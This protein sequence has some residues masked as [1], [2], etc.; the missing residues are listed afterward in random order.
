MKNHV[1][2]LA[3]I[4][5]L[6][7]GVTTAAEATVVRAGATVV[8]IAAVTRGT[9]V[10][11]DSINKIYLVVGSH[12]VL[13][14][15]FVQAD[16]TPVGAAFQIQ[17]NPANFAHFPRVAFS[18]DANGGAGGFL[19]TWHE[20]APSVHGRM[21]SVGQGGPYGA[22]T[23]LTND[24]TWWEVGAAVAYSTVSREFLVA[25]RS[26]PFAG[27]PANND[28][29]VVRVDNA[30]TP[31]A[32][33]FAITN[34]IQ[35]QDNPSVAYNPTTDEFIVVFAGFQDAGNFA[36]LDAQRVKAGANQL[37][38]GPVRLH[39]ASGI[40]IT[41]VTYNSASNAFCAGWY[42]LPSAAA[43]GR[44]IN[45]DGSLPGNII[46][47]STTW[48][49]YD[50]LSMA[51]NRRSNS[52]F[53]V[54]H[55]TAEDGGVE[56]SSACLPVNNGFVVTAAGGNGNYYPRLAAS[57]DDPNWLMS[58]SNTF[59]STMTQ[60]LAGT[61]VQDPVNPPPPPPPP[62]TTSAPL[63]SVDV[64]SLNAQVSTTGFF[65]SGWAL[66]RGAGLG[67]GS[68][69]DFVHVYA[70]P[71]GGGNPT[72]LGAATL[73]APP[74]PD[75][76]GAYGSQFIGSGYS[77]TTG[78]LPPGLYDVTVYAHNTLGNTIDGRIVRVTVVAPPSLPRMWVDLPAVNQTT[79]QNLTVAGWALDLSSSSN[80]GV[81]VVQVYAYPVSG[82]A[83]VFV[84]AAT[85]GTPRGD[86]GAAF[87]SSR[88]N[89]SGFQLT[90]T[91]AA[92]DYTLVVY[93]RSRVTGTFNNAQAVPIKVR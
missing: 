71:V 50:A 43:L 84:G 93:A 29:H 78:P 79:S 4:M 22:D 17:A 55:G 73:G 80:A 3:A 76:A 1:R 92:G 61:A 89:A 72:F 88:F 48:K 58:T 27:G 59:T 45:A 33:V 32:P 19:V 83:P 23:Q 25:W 64:P 15:R 6:A 86:V 38:G 26:L 67:A 77:L 53:M 47:L 42:A 81:D 54:S 46:T 87:G 49:A 65:V 40:Y 39:Q 57:T 60:L 20:G 41:D 44:V 74:R 9:A 75:V 13:R 69:I 37:V 85:Y 21:V 52:F 11:Y 2:T 90:A 14:G 7:L 18:P 10:A 62:A 56:L 66:D 34:D 82:G 36:F 63:M 24:V 5:L 35:Y 91:L 12:G 51:Y 68:G 30:A 28:I 31:K 8:A 16:G 70:W